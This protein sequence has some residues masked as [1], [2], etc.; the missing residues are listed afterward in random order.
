MP[1][2]HQIGVLLMVPS[3]FVPDRRVRRTISPFMERADRHPGSPCQFADF[4]AARTHRYASIV[5]VY[6]RA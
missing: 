6:S 2:S 1:M 5:T 4:H 3:P